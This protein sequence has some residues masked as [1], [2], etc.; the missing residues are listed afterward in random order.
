VLDLD[1]ETARRNTI[2]GWLLVGAFVVL[3]AG[4]VIVALIYL[5]VA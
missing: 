2:L 1:P 3:L 4:V 5:A